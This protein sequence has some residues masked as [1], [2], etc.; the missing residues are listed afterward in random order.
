MTQNQT[1]TGWCALKWDI[2]RWFRLSVVCDGLL[3]VVHSVE[4]LHMLLGR[5]CLPGELDGLLQYDHDAWFHRC[6]VCSCFQS[7]WYGIAI[8]CTRILHIVCADFV[9]YEQIMHSDLCW[10]LVAHCVIITSL[11]QHTINSYFR[12]QTF[13]NPVKC[14]NLNERSS[15]PSSKPHCKAFMWLI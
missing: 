10:R 9:D 6:K 15:T 1:N 14:T 4:E 13:Y 5:D 11:S 12:L 7:L 8:L 3:Q 2:L